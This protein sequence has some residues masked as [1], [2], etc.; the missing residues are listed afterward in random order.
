MLE[1]SKETV[2]KWLN[3]YGALSGPEKDKLDAA[4][5]TLSD[6]YQEIVHLRWREKLKPPAIGAR[7]GITR[8]EAHRQCGVAVGHL[9]R[10]LN[11]FVVEHK[12]YTVARRNIVKT[13]KPEPVQAAKT[14]Q[15]RKIRFVDAINMG[16]V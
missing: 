8:Q 12:N 10:V 2:L 1:I 4:L 11:G 3:N 14:E 13:V 16:L 5:A 6:K 15:S 7:L 9:Y